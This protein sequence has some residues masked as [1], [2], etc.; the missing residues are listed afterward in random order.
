MTDEQA[1]RLIAIAER[2]SVAL[3][4]EETRVQPL[5]PRPARRLPPHLQERVE[6][7]VEEKLD[8][9]VKPDALK[10]KT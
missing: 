5:P 4:A 6:D 2:I 7:L 8:E 10:S 3:E 9:R 1:E